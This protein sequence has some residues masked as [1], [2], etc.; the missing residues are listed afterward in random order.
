M[1]RGKSSTDSTPREKT[2]E[3]MRLQFN[4]DEA[5]RKENYEKALEAL[6]K[7]RDPSKEA[8]S[9]LSS[10]DRKMIREY[11][12]KPYASEA[13]LREAATYLYFRNQILYRLC[14]WYASM[15]A[16]DCRQVIPTYSFTKTND[17]NNMLKQYEATLD[18]LDIYNI[19]GGWHDVA[20]R[21]YLEDVCFTIFFRD[22]TGAFFYI[23]NP[24]ECKIEDRY[25]YVDSS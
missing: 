13:K 10:Y 2:I 22:K 24:D 19:Q 25:Y 12:K 15:W 9:S 20:L 8:L 11:L 17:P 6:K 23:L 5:R 18:T 1:A 14:H 3:E 7:F 4:S 21:C 16:L